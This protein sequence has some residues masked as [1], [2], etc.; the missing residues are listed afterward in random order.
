MTVGNVINQGSTCT[1]R[2]N[3]DKASDYTRKSSEVQFGWLENFL[4][5]RC[6]YIGNQISRHNKRCIRGE[7]KRVRASQTKENIVYYRYTCICT[8]TCT[9][10]DCKW[11]MGDKI[12]GARTTQQTKKY[13][14]KTKNT[15]NNLTPKSGGGGGNF[16]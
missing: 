14:A 5:K 12:R 10:Q 13:M 6:E 11:E 7:N 9:K 15:S 16:Q 2:I 4:Q 1:Y 3:T 8:C